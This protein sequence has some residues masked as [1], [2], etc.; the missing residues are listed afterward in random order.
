[1]VVAAYERGGRCQ[2]VLGRRTPGMFLDLYDDCSALISSRTIWNP[3][4]ILTNLQNG[5]RNPL[6]R[7]I[8]CFLDF[9]PFLRPSTRTHSILAYS[10]TFSHIL[11]CVSTG[12]FRSSGPFI[13]PTGRTTARRRQ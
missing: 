3:N 11:D 13:F 6:D 8:T 1:M 9:S 12:R 4:L 5:K 2:S 10:G 7:Q